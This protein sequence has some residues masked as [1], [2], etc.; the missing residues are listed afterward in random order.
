MFLVE[1]PLQN[2]ISVMLD[3]EESELTFIEV[4]TMKV[5]RKS[6]KFMQWKIF[7]CTCS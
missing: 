5:K 3:G 4:D 7:S 6:K 1:R 2:T